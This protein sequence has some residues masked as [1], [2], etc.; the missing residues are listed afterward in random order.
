M[1]PEELN[2]VEDEWVVRMS[3]RAWRMATELEANCDR[4]GLDFHMQAGVLF[5]AAKGTEEEQLWREIWRYVEARTCAG[6]SDRFLVAI[7]VD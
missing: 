1:G 4:C 7:D 5:L 3:V 6:W 2:D